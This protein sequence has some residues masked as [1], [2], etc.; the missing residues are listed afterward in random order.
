MADK[1]ISNKGVKIKEL[2]PSQRYP[3]EIKGKYIVDEYKFD[4]SMIS[5]SYDKGTKMKLFHN[6]DEAVL[7]IDERERNGNKIGICKL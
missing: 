7:W 1:W 5:V 3:F 2:V 4:K 6:A